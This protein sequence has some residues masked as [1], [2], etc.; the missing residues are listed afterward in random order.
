[1]ISISATTELEAVNIMLTNIGESPVSTLEDEDVVDAGIAKNIL[2]SVNREIQSRGWWFNTDVN[3][4]MICNT[5]GE[6]V[7]PL[8][9]LKVDTSGSHRLSHDLVQRGSK[10]Y[11]RKNHTFL[12]NETIEASLVVGLDFYDLP[13]TAKRYIILRSARIFQE[14]MLGAPSVSA[15]NEKDESLARAMLISE[16]DEACDNNM[17]SD[18][19]STF[20]IINRN[21]L[22][23]R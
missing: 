20:Q 16:D 12:I 4:K 19:L 6:V 22:M 13:E 9:T 8:N 14:R 11:D 7:L 17:L 10:L 23:M 18:N 21:N 3:Y 1:M 5:K 15:F 2:A